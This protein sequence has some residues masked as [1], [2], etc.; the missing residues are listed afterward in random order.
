MV[1][2]KEKRQAKMSLKIF[3]MQSRAKLL[4]RFGRGE[5]NRIKELRHKARKLSNFVK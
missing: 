5:E 4:E 2:E 3:D 1:T